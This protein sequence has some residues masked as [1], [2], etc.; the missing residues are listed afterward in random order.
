MKKNSAKI[1]VIL[2]NLDSD[3]IDKAR[4]IKAVANQYRQKLFKEPVTFNVGKYEVKVD[5]KGDESD[6]DLYISCTCNYWKYQG[7]EYH[8]V[9]NNYLL[10]KTRG[11]ASKPEKRDPDNKHKVCKHVYSVLR[12]Y[13][14]A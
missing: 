14:G 6:P 1:D 13:F 7:A 2:D 5:A 4:S 9:R 10:G 12:D 8:A 11:T 3:V